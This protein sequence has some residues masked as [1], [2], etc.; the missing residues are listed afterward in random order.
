MFLPFVVTVFVS[1]FHPAFHFYFMYLLH[2]KTVVISLALKV[3]DVLHKLI[4]TTFWLM[5]LLV[6]LQRWHKLDTGM[7]ARFIEEDITKSFFLATLDVQLFPFLNVESSY[8]CYLLS[9]RITVH[10]NGMLFDDGMEVIIGK[11]SRPF[12]R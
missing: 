4:H 6:N 7:R 3:R 5:L 11:F 2:C 10:W 8:I 1:T 9:I 12:C